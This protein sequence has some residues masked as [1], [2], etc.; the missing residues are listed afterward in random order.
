MV[1]S[2]KVTPD[3]ANFT[4]AVLFRPDVEELTVPVIS[5]GSCTDL[6][7][8]CRQVLP[9]NTTPGL[10]RE[11]SVDGSPAEV[12]SS[13]NRKGPWYSESEYRGVLDV[14]GWA[15]PA[16]E[17]LSTLVGHFGQGER[18]TKEGTLP[19]GLFGEAVV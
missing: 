13:R 8:V 12:V 15:A 16:I 6:R 14:V 18:V 1:L 10:L 2:P 5:A 9:A 11:S 7:I 3:D 4:V 19:V 17:L